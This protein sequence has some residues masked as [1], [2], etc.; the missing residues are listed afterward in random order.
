MG[1]IL[2]SG[3]IRSYCLFKYLKGYAFVFEIL[4][5]AKANKVS[6]ARLMKPDIR[7]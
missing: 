2:K 6:G 7:S 3:W 4:N 1:L 5:K